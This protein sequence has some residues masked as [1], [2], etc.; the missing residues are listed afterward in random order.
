MH[1]QIDDRW[2]VNAAISFD[3]PISAPT[4]WGHMHE[5]QQFITHDPLHSRVLIRGRRG[6]ATLASPFGL[7]LLISHRL[8]GVGPDRIGRIVR[9]REQQSFAFSDLSK[10]GTRVGFPH[11]CMYDIKSV[12]DDGCRLTFA[13]RGRWTARWVPRLVVKVWLSW[14]LL[15]TRRCIQSGLRNAI[16]GQMRTRSAQ[17]TL[18][19]R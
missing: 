8:L 5:F 11:V 6:T 19:A 14:V 7:E 2:R 15:E 3:L 4:L 13:A 1:V 17:S 18:R 12:S 16:K 9:W 10:R